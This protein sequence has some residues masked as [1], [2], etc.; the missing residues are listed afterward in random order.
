MPFLSSDEESPAG[1]ESLDKGD[2][3][4]NRYFLSNN[5][6]FFDYK[7]KVLLPVL[8]YFV[9]YTSVWCR[10]ISEGI[11]IGFLFSC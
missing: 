11:F 1:E 2:E 10:G 7:V 6:L 3:L 4:Q 8:S 9:L 5:I